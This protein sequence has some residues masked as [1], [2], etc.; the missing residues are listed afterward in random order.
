MNNTTSNYEIIKDI[1]EKSS[2]EFDNRERYYLIPLMAIYDKTKHGFKNIDSSKFSKEYKISANLFAVLA[3]LS[4]IKRVGKKGNYKYKWIGKEPNDKMIKEVIE[5]MRE[6]E[7]ES[8]KA[9][10]ERKKQKKIEEAKAQLEK[11]STE[12]NQVEDQ[13]IEFDQKEFV[14]RNFPNDVRDFLHS[15]NLEPLPSETKKELDH[16][17]I[18]FGGFEIKIKPVYK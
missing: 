12:Q 15:P 13:P 10:K 5:K 6:I 3:N 16:L 17:I 1:I 14:K 11:A 2:F 18:S 4:I 8:F 9:S 7:R